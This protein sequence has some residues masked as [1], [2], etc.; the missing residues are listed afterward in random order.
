MR[1]I[2]EGQALDDIETIFEYISADDPETAAVFAAKLPRD[3]DR[4]LSAGPRTG[5]PGRVEGTLELVV[6]ARYIVVYLI[7][8]TSDQLR[9]IHVRHTSRLWPEQFD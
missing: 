6:H 2:W 5:R 3:T 4:R 7:D 1:V 9:I 8:E